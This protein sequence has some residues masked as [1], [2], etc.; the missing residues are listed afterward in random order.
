MDGCFNLININNVINRHD[1]IN[2]IS[3]SIHVPIGIAVMSK[4]IRNSAC[5]AS[6]LGRC[7][8]YHFQVVFFFFFSP[9][10]DLHKIIDHSQPNGK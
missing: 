10:I 9:I 1:R 4:I 5:L 6:F 2:L 7:Y 8:G 3:P